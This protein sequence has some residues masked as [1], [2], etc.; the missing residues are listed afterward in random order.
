MIRLQNL[1]SMSLF[2]NYK[3][4]QLIENNNTYFNTIHFIHQQICT[5]KNGRIIKLPVYTLYLY[6]T[7]NK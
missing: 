1:K 2:L 6:K 3:V 7:L 5:E 4:F